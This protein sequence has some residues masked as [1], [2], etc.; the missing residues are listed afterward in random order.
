MSRYAGPVPAPPIGKNATPA[1]TR[2]RPR[3]ASPNQRGAMA[4]NRSGLPK[5]LQAGI[6]RLSGLAMDDVR[7]HRD[8]AEPARLGALAYTKG[9]DIHLG[10]GQE[11]HLPHEAWHAVQQKQG[12]VKATT[13]LK[14][15]AVNGDAALE[16]EADRMG[17]MALE[18][19]STTIGS[20]RSRP[21]TEPAPVVQRQAAPRDPATERADAVAEL[22]AALSVTNEQLDA[23]LDAEDALKLKRRR[24]KDK[25]YAWAVARRD[26]ARLEKNW[27]MSPALQQELTVK[28]RF[29]EGEARGA[30]IRTISAVLSTFPSEQVSEIIAPMTGS[31][32]PTPLGAQDVPCDI[33]K[34]EFLLQYE[35]E[36]D[37]N[38]CVD[39]I[40]DREFA[41]Y[42]FDTNIKS[43]TAFAVP[44]TTW[45]NVQYDSF[46]ALGVDY[47][48]GHSELFLLND[49]GIFPGADTLDYSYIKSKTGLIYPIY[50]NK[51]YVR[52]W[53]APNLASL[54]RGLQY[55]VKE[56]GDLY[57]LLQVGGILTINMGAYGAV[58][59]SFKTAI[60]AFAKRGPAVLPGR[61][62]PGIG[63]RTSGKGGGSNNATTSGVPVHV[64]DETTPRMTAAQQQEASGE[65]VGKFRII[66]FE[67][68]E[69]V[70]TK[71]VRYISGISNIEGKPKV[72]GR[73]DVRSIKAVFPTLMQD[74]KAKG[75]TELVIVG[76]EIQNPDLLRMHR[77][78]PPGAVY[79]SGGNP[80]MA[81]GWIN[82]VIPLQ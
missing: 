52:D 26:K 23:Q 39:V 11:Q 32:A 64:P 19:Q 54:R 48:D 34:K 51:I 78:L 69:L 20:G 59:G 81:E 5:S 13:Q 6:E 70:G 8:S 40:N 72:T 65:I 16:R 50:R 14:G 49:I 76:R 79:E 41:T 71:Y 36:P 9:A 18:A 3:A 66:S 7:V 43:G 27:E 37:K 17:S 53:L 67:K 21:R 61:P 47:R 4:P 25:E 68:P 31:A 28:M 44:G 62:L 33:A 60:N 15:A 58:S 12:R 38:R 29:F 46:K 2:P 57:L 10:P 42:Y 1:A 30:Y 24:R 77:L 75:A 73:I 35:D 55:Q 22:E 56:L 63:V 74:A 45:E 82:L 80:A